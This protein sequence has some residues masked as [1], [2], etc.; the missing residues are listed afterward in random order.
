MAKRREASDPAAVLRELC[1]RVADAAPEGWLRASVTGVADAQGAGQTGVAYDLADGAERVVEM[2]LQSVLRRAYRAFGEAGR[3]LGVEA[4]VT[5]SGEFEVAT[6]C[7]LS[8]VDRPKRGFLYMIDADAL[9]A[10]PGDEQD[11]PVDS[12]QAGDPDEAVRLLRAYLRY[13]DEL[14]GFSDEAPFRNLPAPPSAESLDRLE[15]RLGTALPDDLRA[16]YG[17]ADGDGEA[18]VFE[19]LSCWLSV[20]AVA[21]V[22]GGDRHWAGGGRTE[23]FFGPFVPDADPPGTVRRSAD[24]PGWIPFV[25]CTGGDLL[26][27]DMDPAGGGRPGQVIRLGAGRGVRYVADSVTSLLRRH[28]DAFARGAYT[29]GD[30][31]E[32]RLDA[33]RD[34]PG[35]SVQILRVDGAGDVDLGSARQAPHLLA[36]ELSRCASA[37]LS[38]LR[39][40]PVETLDLE[41]KSIDL[42]PLAGHPTL[43]R[44]T[45][46]APHAVDLGPL[47]TLPRLAHLDVSRASVHHL[48]VIAE[49]DGLR[50][51]ALRYEQWEEWWSLGERL[52]GL[53]A[54]FLVGK[55]RHDRLAAWLAEFDARGVRPR[56]G[57]RRIHSGRL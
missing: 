39:E 33:P 11:G 55:G 57:A 24:R 27:V 56:A 20:E 52:P 15:G 41:L 19:R 2:D 6:G 30:D 34:E 31:G 9:P 38:P 8:G 45:L 17:V 40:A 35:P 16:L 47:R 46:S 23:R 53:A 54:A 29:I 37:D 51:L 21:A 22:H 18:G 42:A 10:D 28:V 5:A 49:L 12:T 32:L 13:R 36:V 7:E 3:V 4:G 50:S 14:F 48:R 43:R 25:L 26:A 44:V 1:S